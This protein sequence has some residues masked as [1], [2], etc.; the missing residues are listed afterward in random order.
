MTAVAAINMD[1][2]IPAGAADYAAE[3]RHRFDQDTIVYSLLP[4]MHL[5]GK[6]FRFEAVFPT[7]VARCCWT[8]RGTSSNGRNVDD[9]LEAQADAAGTVLRCLARYD[10]SADNP[11]NP[12]PKRTV[13]WGQTR[14]EMLVGYVEVALDSAGLRPRRATG[15]PAR[16]RPLRGHVPLP[17]PGRYPV[18]LPGR[19][20]Q[21]LEADRGLDGRPRQD[22]R[23]PDQA[24]PRRGGRT[25][26]STSS[27]APDGATTPATA[28]RRAI[29]T[30][31]CWSWA[32]AL[33]GIRGFV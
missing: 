30:T 18:G 15:P 2:H 32:S 20:L 13:T 19:H 11:S 12:D 26:T 28:A 5:R 4:H 16:R 23:V 31:A 17:S 14:D 29:T 22:G 1:L 6:S 3:A 8:S 21:R 9:A 7:A 10:N 24:D 25:N 33:K 27:K